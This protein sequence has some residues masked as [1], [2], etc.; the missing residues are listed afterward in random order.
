MKKLGFQREILVNIYK[1]LILS[2]VISNST[3]LCSANKSITDE[4][5]HIQD[6]VLKIIDIKKEDE[7]KFKIEPTSVVIEKHCK[8]TM[9]KILN[10]P[11]HNI[12]KSL[13]TKETIRTRNK[14]PF[15]IEKCNK[16]IYQQSFVQQYLRKLEAE[17]ENY[18]KTNENNNKTVQEIDS[19]SKEGHKCEICDK[20]CL[21]KAGLKA[22]ERKKH[23]Y[24]H[25]TIRRK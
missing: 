25:V 15:Q 19:M 5:Q 24:R 13:K 16:Q 2:Q 14:F 11:D 18:F 21:S 12:T 20:I 22:H 6:K 1:S 10:N 4:I 8:S 23:M 3:V 7:E 17:N 9:S